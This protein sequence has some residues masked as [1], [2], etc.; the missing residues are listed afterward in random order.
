MSE[1]IAVRKAL[2]EP[3]SS[4]LGFHITI[5]LRELKNWRVAYR[6]RGVISSHPSVFA[7]MG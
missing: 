4:G 1:L 3:F 5:S 6:S 7:L 2:F